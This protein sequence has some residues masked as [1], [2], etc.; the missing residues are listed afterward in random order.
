MPR[1][2]RGQSP[3]ILLTWWSYPGTIVPF[4]NSPSGHRYW[5]PKHGRIEK[6]TTKRVSYPYINQGQPFYG[7]GLWVSEKVS[8][9]TLQ[10]RFAAT[11][12]EYVQAFHIEYALIR[13]RI[14][15]RWPLVS[16]A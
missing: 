2:Q 16:S 1:R 13:R 9:G 7:W 3:Y 15:F 10:G 14:V 8:Q 5:Y 11:S 12:W 6:P 4:A